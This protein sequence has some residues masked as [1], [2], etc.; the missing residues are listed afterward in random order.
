MSGGSGGGAV[1]ARADDGEHGRGMREDRGLRV[2]RRDE[3]VFGACEHETRQR[4][5]QRL[6]DRGERVARFWKPL[7]EVFAHP[8]FLRAL[9]RAEPD[10]T[11]HR[12]TMLAQVKPA[13][14]A[15]NITIMPGL[16]LPVFTAS[17]SAMAVDAAEVL[18]NRSTFTYTLSIGTPAC[19]AVASMMRMFAWCGIR[20]SMSAA[21]RPA[22]CSAWSHASAIERTA[23]LKTSRPAILM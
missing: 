10:R 17:S 5:A 6:V 23:A 18:P 3:L 8:D 16:S 19:F 2:L 11:Y 7:R 1:H 9:A 4:H 14:K 15:T 22:R 12:T 13:P 21:V 20:R